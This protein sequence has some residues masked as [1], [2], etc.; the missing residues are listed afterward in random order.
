[1][2]RFKSNAAPAAPLVMPSMKPAEAMPAAVPA[3]VKGAS[4]GFDLLD[5][6][7]RVHA[8]LIDELDLSALE[9]LDDDTMRQR[10]RG[11][12]SEIIRK[13][14]MALSSVEEISFADAVMDEMT[15]LGP[16]EPLLKDDS[17]ADILINGYNQVYIERNGELQLAPVRFADNDHLLRIVQRIVSAVGR[18][19]DESQPLVDARLL[20]G[21]RV[22]AA[23]APIAIDGPLV[24]IRKFS[25]SPLTMEKL[26][27][28]GAI[29]GPVA[30]FILGAV[31]CKASTVISG[32]TGSGKT[33]LLNALSS[34]I[35]P[36]ER[37]ITIEDAAELQLQQPH[38]ARMETRPPNI[39]G[40]GEIRQRELV[41]NALRMRPDRVIL[42][43]VR[44]E[45]AF[46]MLQAMNTGHEGS[47]ATIHANN[48][49]DAI[50]RLEQ[51]VMMGGM[52]ISEEAIRGQIASAVNFIVQATR[53]SDGSRKVVSI[54]EITGMEGS[55]IQIQE[56]FKFER[57][58]TS[59]DGKV[60]GKFVATGLRPKFLDEMERRGVHMPAG[61]FDP[62]TE[63]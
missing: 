46:D 52:K 10:V 24:S 31:K 58:G 50:T 33:T 61:M 53:L 21:S 14:E 35:S 30:E 42:G 15:G 18:R 51:M 13:E 12:I 20:D 26:V 59:E 34:A 27:G 41:K 16:I 60:I 23:I 55:I 44:G 19:V 40:K 29:P 11:I 36:K 1:M 54:A 49:R 56:I 25:K 3:K 6:K 43:E 47:M 48:P 5:A 28:F 32:G 45:E 4:A 9:K 38:V 63:F 57:S 62:A 2:S 17:I 8:K 39:E 7:L 37:L 22:N